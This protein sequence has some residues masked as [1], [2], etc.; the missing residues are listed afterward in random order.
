MFNF[1]KINKIFGGGKGDAP[2]IAD[3][4][5]SRWAYEALAVTQFKDNRFEQNFFEL[6]KWESTS[7]YKQVFYIPEL[8][9]I[10]DESLVL[11]KESDRSSSKQLSENLILLKNEFESESELIPNLP[12]VSNA[13]FNPVT[14][15]AETAGEARIFIKGLEDNYITIYNKIS[16]KKNQEIKSLQQEYGE[17]GYVKLYDDYTNDFLSDVVKK[18]TSKNKILRVNN[19]L[20]QNYEPIFLEPGRNAV[21]LRAHFFAPCKY[22][23]GLKLNT[24]TFNLIVIWLMSVIFYITLYFDVLKKTLEFSGR[25]K[26][27][28]KES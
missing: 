7:N 14:F 17:V 22:F 24:I 3:V 19:R 2:V 20:V 10:I 8:N 27:I 15:N 6:D 12:T 11:S 28:A 25:H 23:F 21:S 5:A 1:D 18:A 16:E 4:M 9:K 13:V 26:R